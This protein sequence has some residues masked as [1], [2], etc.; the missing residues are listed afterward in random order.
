MNWWAVLLAQELL[1]NE[2]GVGKAVRE[3]GVPRENVW[4]TSKVRLY[5]QQLYI[6]D[7]VT[8]SALEYFPLEGALDEGQITSICTKVTLPIMNPGLFPRIPGT[9]RES[10]PYGKV[11]NRGLWHTCS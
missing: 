6:A 10:L 5:A 9:H 11:R 1:Q 8:F 7:D 3:S 4:L 2:E